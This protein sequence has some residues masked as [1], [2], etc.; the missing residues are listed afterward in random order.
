M[1][2]GFDEKLTCEG[3]I[4]DGCGGGRLFT[5]DD[6]KLKA[7][8]PKTEETMILLEN[9]NG[10]TAISKKGCTVFITCKEESIEFDLSSMRKTVKKI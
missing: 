6:N 5:I 2:H 8:D 7:Y 4:G 3:I 9:V 10:A 1:I